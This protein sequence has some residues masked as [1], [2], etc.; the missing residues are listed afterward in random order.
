MVSV[1]ID[2]DIII[3]FLRTQAGVYPKLVELQADNKLEI[4]LSAVTV[5]E[6]FA[7]QSSKSKEQGEILQDIFSRT[8]IVPLDFGLSRVAGE[9]KRD[10]KLSVAISDLII[11][12]TAVYLNASLAT[13]NRRHF[14]G[15]KSVKFFL[16]PKL[17]HKNPD[18]R[19]G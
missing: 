17:L 15:L 8:K 2:T 6:L 11:A 4:I 10:K 1:V 5:V 13:R 18:S 14:S 19:R 16:L 12:A 9:L 3:D 7:G